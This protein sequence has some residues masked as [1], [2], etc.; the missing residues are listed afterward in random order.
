MVIRAASAFQLVVRIGCILHSAGQ[1]RAG[2]G[3][4]AVQSGT[5]V[6]GSVPGLRVLRFF[7]DYLSG[8]LDVTASAFQRFAGD[9]AE[10]GEKGDG[11]DHDCSP[12]L[13]GGVWKA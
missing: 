12:C 6:A 2:F 7:G 9:E 10:K 11:A 13:G 8:G 1:G 5:A 4:S 3:K